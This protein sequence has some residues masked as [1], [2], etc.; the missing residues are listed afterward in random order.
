MAQT[1]LYEVE[2]FNVSHASENKIHDDVV[3]KKLGFTGA[4]VPGVEVYAYASHLFLRR[5]GRAWLERGTAEC[6]FFK[7]VY[8]GRIARATS[9]A[10]ASGLSVTVESEGVLCAS[11][12]AALPEAVVPVSGHY[13]SF[14]PPAERPMASDATLAEGL[15]LCT[16]PTVMGA[17]QQADYLRDVREADPVY[18]AEKLVHP[19]Q[20]LRLCNQTLTQN[21]VVNPWIHVGSRVRNLGLAR[22]GQEMQARARV[23]SN[24]DRK[25]HKLVDLDVLVLADGQPVAQVLHTAVWRPRQLAEA[26]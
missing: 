4:L 15:W 3:A 22:V 19:G 6:R 16:A 9:E 13:P 20:I 14:L 7:P 26:A 5:W 2:A 24:Y 17:A 18:G 12:E 25:G 21:V 23:V 1:E 10:T 11:G 8:D